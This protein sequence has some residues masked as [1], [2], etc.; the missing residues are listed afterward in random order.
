MTQCGPGKLC[1]AGKQCNP[2]KTVSTRIVYSNAWIK[3]R[4][5]NVIR[6]D[7]KPGIYGVVESRAATGVVAVNSAFEICLVGQYRY[8]VNTY[9]WEIIEGGAEFG[10]APIE[11]VK[12]ELREEAGLAAQAWEQL[13]NVIHL[14]NCHSSEEGYLYLAQELTAVQSAPDAT[15]ELQLKYVPFAECVTMVESGEITDAMS[16]I[17]ILRAERVLKSRDILR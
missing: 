1:G 17:G 12:R 16:I 4:E 5:D 6:P 13:G 11:A 9:S 15:E 14:S 10:E 3:V 2:W 7:G 8:P